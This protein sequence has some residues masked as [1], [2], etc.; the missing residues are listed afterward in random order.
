MADTASEGSD[1]ESD[2]EVN[3]NNLETLQLAYHELLS[4]SSIMSK[5]Y[6]NL[7]K[8]FKSLS[9]DYKQLQGKHE[10]KIDNSS[11]ISTQSCDD[12]ESLK[13]KTTKFHLENEEICKERSIL[14]EDL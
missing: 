11:K 5:V 10:E 4:N 8:D 3:I 14:M 12:F 2:E 6:Q 1:S 7:R 13:L 9:K